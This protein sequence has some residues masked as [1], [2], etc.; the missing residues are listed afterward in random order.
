[1]QRLPIFKLLKSR[2]PKKNLLNFLMIHKLATSTSNWNVL[3]AIAH[4]E[5]SKSVDFHCSTYGFE[6]IGKGKNPPPHAHFCTYPRSDLQLELCCHLT[7]LCSVSLA[8]RYGQETVRQ[9]DFLFQLSAQITLLYQVSLPI[10][11]SS[12]I[13]PEHQILT[14][15][16]TKSVSA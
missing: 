11:S 4:A 5:F 1:M 8:I 9:I 6:Q 2:T 3:V 12:L 16:Q 13:N 14:K 10:I 7:W 15:P